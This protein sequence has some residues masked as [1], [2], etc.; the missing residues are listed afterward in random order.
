MHVNLLISPWGGLCLLHTAQEAMP[1][2]SLIDLCCGFEGPGQVWANDNSKML[3]ALHDLIYLAVD[4]G[5]LRTSS[6]SPLSL[7]H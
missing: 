7:M 3:E 6:K 2:G 5:G 1:L 4:R